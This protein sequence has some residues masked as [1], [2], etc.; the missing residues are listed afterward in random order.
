MPD[1]H[2]FACHVDTFCGR[3]AATLKYD[4]KN[5]FSTLKQQNQCSDTTMLTLKTDIVIALAALSWSHGVPDALLCTIVIV[6]LY[7]L[8]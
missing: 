7:I 4:S 6:F 3:N 2:K 8:H 1:Y 5:T